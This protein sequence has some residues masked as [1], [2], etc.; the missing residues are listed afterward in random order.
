VIF[1]VNRV[2]SGGQHFG[3]R[4]LWLPHGTLLVSIGDGGNPPLHLDGAMFR[5][6][7]QDRSSHLGKVVRLHDDGTFPADNPFVDDP[8]RIRPSGASAIATSG[9][10]GSAP[11]LDGHPRPPGL[12]VYTADRFPQWRGNIFAGG[13]VAR[14][15]RRLE[16]DSLGT[17]I[18]ESILPIGARVGDVRQGPDGFRYVLTDEPDGRLLRLQPR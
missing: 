11:G 5:L 1:E 6:Q 12:A 10:G 9:D 8:K 3:S 16:L 2:K 15:I 13:L 18:R 14:N 7:A 17:V 4:L